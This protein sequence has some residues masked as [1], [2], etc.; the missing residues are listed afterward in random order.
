MLTEFI[1]VFTNYAGVLTDNS[2]DNVEKT[3]IEISGHDG[4]YI[5]QKY[6]FSNFFLLLEASLT[7]SEEFIIEFWNGIEWIQAVD[8]L[9]FTKGLIRDGSVQFSLPRFQTWQRVQYTDEENTQTPTECVGTNVSD[10]YWLRINT[11]G[12]STFMVKKITYAFT[13]SEKINGIEKNGPKLYETF[14]A[15][16]SDWVDEIIE[17]SEMMVSEMKR[18]GQINSYGQIVAI[19]EF[20]LPCAYRTLVH[21]Y[22]NM[23][24]GY[25]AKKETVSLAYADFLSG[26]KNLDSNLNSKVDDEA[27]IP[28]LYR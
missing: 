3:G 5:A 13:T 2:I 27:T 20:V 10:C 19:E 16:K 18:G 17:A 28:R 25:E 8:V 9:D 11:V 21:I 24:K 22:E 7:S 1:R 14:S 6:P 15:G 4:I 12:L 26:P 23:G